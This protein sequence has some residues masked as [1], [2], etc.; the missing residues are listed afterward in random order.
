MALPKYEKL[1]YSAKI[2]LKQFTNGI[3][4]VVRFQI[5]LLLGTGRKKAISNGMNDFAVNVQI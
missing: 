2:D 1:H 4:S 5:I 3:Y